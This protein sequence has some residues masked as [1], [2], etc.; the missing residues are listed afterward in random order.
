MQR[1]RLLWDIADIDYTNIALK[2][3]IWKSCSLL[4]GRT[5]DEIKQLLSAEVQMSLRLRVA[6]Y[7]IGASKYP[8]NFADNLL[9]N[10]QSSATASSSHA[11]SE[12]KRKDPYKTKKKENTKKTDQ[13]SAQYQEQETEC[14]HFLK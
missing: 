1:H 11:T 6:N 3:K 8:P 13:H 7:R 9:A 4:L 10:N 5:V 2:D 14:P 12:S